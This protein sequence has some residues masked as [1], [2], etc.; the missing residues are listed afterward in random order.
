MKQRLLFASTVLALSLAPMAM[1]LHA[2]PQ[3]QVFVS[4]SDD[5]GP[6]SFRAAVAQANGNAAITRIHFLGRVDTIQLNSTV[7]FSGAQNLTI[8]GNGAT[9]DAAE[10]GRPAFLT[11]GGGDLTVNALTV[12]NS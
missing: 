3:S 8:D 6:G 5:A 1:P 11:T 4:N 12:R 10:A 7:T 2:A 9:L